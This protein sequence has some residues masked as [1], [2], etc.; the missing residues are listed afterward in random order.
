MQRMIKSIFVLFLLGF[1]TQAQTTET[2]ARGG[3]QKEYFKTATLEDVAACLDT[4][5]DLNVRGDLGVTPLHRAARYT[6]NPDVIKTLLSAGADL[7]AKDE[8][9]RTP[10]HLAAG[11]NANPDITKA[12]IDAGAN[13]ETR[14]DDWG[15]TALHC[16]AAWNENPDVAK[17][18]MDAGAD[19]NARNKK[20]NTPLE[21]AKWNNKNKAVIEVCAIV[22]RGNHRKKAVSSRQQPH[23]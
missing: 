22:G 23:F 20:G 8:L 7:E 18:L 12:L 16:A 17:V 1:F 11:D 3:I 19:I 4:G 14:G 13:L 15:F 5:V 21:I 2:V 10:L 6:E 9:E